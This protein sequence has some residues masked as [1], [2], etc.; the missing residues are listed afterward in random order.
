MYAQVAKLGLEEPEL[1]F[2][3]DYFKQQP[4]TFYTVGGSL[5]LQQA[6]PVGAHYFIKHFQNLGCLYKCF[7]QNIDGLEIVAGIDSDVLVQ[8]HG[9]MRSA[10]CIE[11]K[12]AV[13][14]DKFYE[15]IKEKRVLRCQRDGCIEGLIKPDVIF[16]GEALPERFLSNFSTIQHA[17]LVIIMGTHIHE[18]RLIY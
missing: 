17:D 7:T 8:A 16:F 12:T 11:C 10:R 18:T 2:T 15:A 13:D 14:M 4:E 9:H 3:L 6:R 1:I 5:L